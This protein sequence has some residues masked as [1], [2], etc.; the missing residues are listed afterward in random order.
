MRALP[1]EDYP[2]ARLQWHF[3]CGFD[4]RNNVRFP[5]ILRFPAVFISLQGVT[6]PCFVVPE[7]TMGHSSPWDNCTR[8]VL[9]TLYFVETKRIHKHLFVSEAHCKSTTS[10]ISG[11][12]EVLKRIYQSVDEIKSVKL[13]KKVYN[14]DF[15]D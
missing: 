7:G 3:T 13:H 5:E 15:K 12:K 2:G 8:M 11:K 10:K 1:S 4:F 9:H 14:I 6:Y